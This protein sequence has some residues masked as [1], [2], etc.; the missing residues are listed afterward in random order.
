MESYMEIVGMLEYCDNEGVTSFADL[1]R[2]A[3]ENNYKS[4]L[5]VLCSFEGAYVVSKFLESSK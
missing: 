2:Y 3:D 1:F 4:W 5:Q